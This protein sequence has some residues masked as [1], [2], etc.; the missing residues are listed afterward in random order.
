MPKLTVTI[1]NEGGAVTGL[2]VFQY[3]SLPDFDAERFNSETCIN[4]IRVSAERH[5]YLSD[6]PTMQQLSLDEVTCAPDFDDSFRLNRLN[7]INELW[8][9]IEQVMRNAQLNFAT[10]R[11]F[12]EIEDS[13]SGDSD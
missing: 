2:H 6:F 4:L 9:E 1:T 7:N 3:N 12:K 11:M 5:R 8:A 10:A 13:Y